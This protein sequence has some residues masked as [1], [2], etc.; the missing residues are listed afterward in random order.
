MRPASF[1]QT[2]M[3]GVLALAAAAGCASGAGGGADPDRASGSGG[4]GGAGGGKAG[5]TGG[6]ISA[7]GGGGGASGDSGGGGGAVVN[8]G[9]RAGGATGGGGKDA[10][11]AETGGAADAE[12][13]VC[14]YPAW[15][16]SAAYKAGDIIMY[17]G[18]PY[19]ALHD[20][21][22]LD[23]TV[24]TFFW[25]PYTG[26]KPPPPPAAALCPLLDKL[27]PRGEATF[28]EM[29]TPPF[30]GWMP[31]GAYSYA[32]LCKA[33]DTPALAAF[34]RSG[35]DMNDKR[36]LAAFFANVA[37]E[38]AYLT[39]IDEQGHGAADKDF[40]G[41]GSLQITGQAIYGECGAALGLNLAGMPQL[42]SQET[43][44]WQTGI[45]YWTSHANP[46][47]P[48][49][50]ICHAAIA[51]GEFGQTVRIIKGDCGSAATRTA[52]YKKN[53]TLLGVP[54]GNTNCP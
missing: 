9:G 51:Q 50:Q 6:A 10:A 32:S 22:S 5:G 28:T 30:M 39:A 40:H 12:L 44:V 24:S 23:P 34:I 46:S 3:T 7:A 18:K 33:L 21:T 25:G 43:A 14:N 19:I 29:F 20:N 11:G 53:C 54:P 38:T 35:N 47:A 2:W 37:I 36:E 49:N 42:A 26:C 41:R 4:R 13:P 16:K 27:L 52:Q 8:G 31:L 48:G 17:M 1:K 45:W 15:S